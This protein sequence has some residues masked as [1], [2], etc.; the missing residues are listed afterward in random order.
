MVDAEDGG[1]VVEVVALFVI[2]S[3]VLPAAADLKYR[4][5]PHRAAWTRAYTRL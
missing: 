3:V 5:Q 4:P 1:P 2:D